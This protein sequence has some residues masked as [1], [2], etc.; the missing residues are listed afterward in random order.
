MVAGEMFEQQVD[1]K[2]VNNQMPVL[3]FNAWFRMGQQEISAT[4][5]FRFQ[6]NQ[7]QNAYGGKMNEYARRRNDAKRVY[8]LAIYAY[9]AK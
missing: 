8:R 9:K 3:K 6:G 7:I 1:S 4:S 5:R 2:V